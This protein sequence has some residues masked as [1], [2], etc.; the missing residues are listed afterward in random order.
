MFIIFYLTIQVQAATELIEV[1]LALE[2]S[3]EQ[4]KVEQVQL[5][6]ALAQ[7]FKLAKVN[8]HDRCSWLKFSCNK[9]DLFVQNTFH[10]KIKKKR[11]LL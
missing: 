4:A 7:S 2:K 5:G 11:Y 6:T 10:W 8:L 9:Q 3:Q 1:K